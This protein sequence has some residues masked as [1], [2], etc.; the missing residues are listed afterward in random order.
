MRVG[1]DVCWVPRMWR[2]V[3]VVGGEMV[4][5]GACAGWPRCWCLNMDMGTTSLA[6]GQR[7]VK[8]SAK[9]FGCRAPVKIEEMEHTKRRDTITA[10]LF[11]CQVRSLWLRFLLTLLTTVYLGWDTSDY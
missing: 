11:G 5:G 4:A 2:G 3:E 7:C 6:G 8:M 9:W 1:R 10:S